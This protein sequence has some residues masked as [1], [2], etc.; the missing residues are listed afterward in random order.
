MNEIQPINDDKKSWA[1]SIWCANEFVQLFET[2]I[3]WRCWRRNDSPDFG[4]VYTIRAKVVVH[5]GSILTSTEFGEDELTHKVCEICIRI[6]ISSIKML[7]GTRDTE[8]EDYANTLR[9]VVL[10]QG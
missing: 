10:R 8:Y 4:H 3:N 6:L 2:H 9:S 5:Y 1:S 7:V